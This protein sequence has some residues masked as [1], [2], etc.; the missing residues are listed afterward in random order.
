MGDFDLTDS[1]SRL[2]QT[3]LEVLQST[4]LLPSCLPPLLHR[5]QTAL[6]SRDFSQASPVPSL[7][8]SFAQI[9]PSQFLFPGE[10]RL[11]TQITLIS[12]KQEKAAVRVCPCTLGTCFL[13]KN[14]SNTLVQVNPYKDQGAINVCFHTDSQ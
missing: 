11:I 7:I 3:F 14:T 9:L 4:T 1:F 13:R 6:Q 2:V 5:G 8:F 10:S 12:E